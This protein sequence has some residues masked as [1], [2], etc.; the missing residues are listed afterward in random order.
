MKP[1]VFALALFVSTGAAA[2]SAQTD[3]VHKTPLQTDPFPGAGRHTVLVHTDVDVGGLVGRHTHPGLEMAYVEKGE[4]VVR[5]DGRPPSHLTAGGSFDVP[6]M[7]VHSVQN[8]GAGELTIVSTY[9]VAADQ[10]IATPVK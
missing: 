5:I 3:N 1:A 2:A 7:V 4:A 8:V 10:P 9:V 6:P